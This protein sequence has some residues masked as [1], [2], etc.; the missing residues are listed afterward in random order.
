MTEGR[1]GVEEIFNHISNTDQIIL[2]KYFHIS[3]KMYFK[4]CFPK[5]Q[6]ILKVKLIQFSGVLLNVVLDR[7][8]DIGYSQRPQS[9]VPMK[10]YTDCV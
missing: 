3:Q 1:E 4:P 2:P 8:F 5:M 10:K 7:F 6:I 9:P